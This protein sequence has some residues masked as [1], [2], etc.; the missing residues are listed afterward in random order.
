LLAGCQRLNPDWCASGSRCAAGEVCDPGTNT[1]RRLEGG[2]PAEAR[3]KDGP[4]SEQL[5]DTTPLDRSRTEGPR[6]DTK[7]ELCG[8]ATD[9][10]VCA[11]GAAW[12]CTEASTILRRNCPLGHCANGHCELPGSASGCK[13][14]AD[15]KGSWI[16]TALLESKLPKLV[17]AAPVLGL[18]SPAVC[19]SGLECACGLCTSS[20]QCY[21]ACDVVGDCPPPYLCKT[22]SVLVEGVS[23]SLK[24]CE[25]P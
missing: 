5:V 25:L 17:C 1:C 7:V 8:S 4:A 9:G 11:G 21:Y 13:R 20:G 15:C 2:S 23:A 3:L 18:P 16:C 24:S 22:V 10:W 19:A 6:P 12:Q 14:N